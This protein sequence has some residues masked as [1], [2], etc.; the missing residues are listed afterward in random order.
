M[1]ARVIA[2]HLRSTAFILADGVVP[3]ATGAPTSGAGWLLTS[4]AAAGRG[5][6][7]RR[8]I[9]RAVGFGEQIGLKEPFLGHLLP[10]LLQSHGVA[11]PELLER[12]T[13][14]LQMLQLEEESFR[15]RLKHGLALLDKV[16]VH[17]G[18]VC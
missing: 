12:E 11:Y 6:V 3:S 5:Y 18:L 10:A 7:L 13:M 14:I 9:R 2:D 1:A 8:L 16:T 17:R 15:D 4:V